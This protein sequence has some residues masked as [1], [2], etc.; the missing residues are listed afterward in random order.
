MVA[1][2]LVYF[3]LFK[4]SEAYSRAVFL[5][6]SCSTPLILFGLH[7][8]VRWLLRFYRAQGRNIRRAVIVGAGELGLRTAHHM[9]EIGRASCRE[10]V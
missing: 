2:L 8:L 6:W 7:L 5:I 10:R 1:S 4:I 9:I 3:F